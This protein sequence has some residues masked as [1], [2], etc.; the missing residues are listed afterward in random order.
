MPSDECV[1]IHSAAVGGEVVAPL[2]TPAAEAA[3]EVDATTVVESAPTPSAST[4]PLGRQI[5]F[6]LSAPTS[7][8]NTSSI[9]EL[10]VPEAAAPPS[11]PATPATPTTEIATPATTA[12]VC[13]SC[14]PPTPPERKVQTNTSRCWTC[15]KKIG[16][17]GFKCKCEYFYCPKHRYPEAHSCDFDYKTKERNDLAKANPKIIADRMQ[18]I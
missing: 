18:K 14:E 10:V 1:A 6:D 12:L 15:N 7:T 2:T 9:S 17:T 11:T 13:G 3:M 5:D 16:L 8:P 4:A